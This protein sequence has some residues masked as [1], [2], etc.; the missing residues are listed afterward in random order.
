MI[1][2]DPKAAADRIRDL[3]AKE[4]TPIQPQDR[5][6][7]SFLEKVCEHLGIEATPLNVAHVAHLMNKAGVDQHQPDE[8]LKMLTRKD[9]D[10]YVIPV[11]YPEGHAK[12]GLNVVFHSREEEDEY[13]R[14]KIGRAHV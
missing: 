10:G 1:N 7:L 9:A 5:H 14:P 13:L 11:K 2:L 8:Y 6:Q 3:L 12:H 4:P